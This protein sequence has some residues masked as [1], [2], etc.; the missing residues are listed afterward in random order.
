MAHISL[1][2]YNQAKQFLDSDLPK[3]QKKISDLKTQREILQKQLNTLDT[4]IENETQ[5]WNTRYYK[6]I[7]L[8]HKRTIKLYETQQQNEHIVMKKIE[9]TLR[10]I[11]LFKNILEKDTKK[12]ITKSK[13]PEQIIQSRTIIDSKYGLTIPKPKNF[14]LIRENHH[15]KL[16]KLASYLNTYLPITDYSCSI[17][18]FTE[19][20]SISH[21]KTMGFT[22]DNIIELAHIQIINQFKHIKFEHFSRYW[23]IGDTAC[24]KKF[25]GVWKD[26]MPKSYWY[27]IHQEPHSKNGKWV[28]GLDMYEDMYHDDL[29]QKYS[30]KE[31]YR[32]KTLRDTYEYYPWYLFI[33]KEKFLLESNKHGTNVIARIQSM[34]DIIYGCRAYNN[35]FGFTIDTTPHNIYWVKANQDNYSNL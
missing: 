14:I 31:Y 15:E 30:E 6:E 11:Q 12:K 26:T 27:N 21:I 24:V 17:D 28:H 4:Q 7:Q 32:R 1:T 3:Q 22:I 23:G 19:F 16:I 5:L 13:T 25:Y 8:T 35:N 2:Q 18:H 10:C 9:Y 29:Q 34:D 20:P 33:T